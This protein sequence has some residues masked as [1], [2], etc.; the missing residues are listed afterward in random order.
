M[1]PVPR[2]TAPPKQLQR[3]YGLPRRMLL[4]RWAESKGDA[5][6]TEALVA[7]T[8]DFWQQYR[9]KRYTYLS[10]AG[11]HRSLDLQDWGLMYKDR[12]GMERNEIELL[13]R[14]MATTDVIPQME[15]LAFQNI[16][17]T[18]PVFRYN[19]ISG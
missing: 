10:E 2:S 14:F 15:Y 7:H 19:R 18:Y 16:L 6:D 1:N 4:H 9:T 17:D 8:I 13:Y 11:S 3:D 12:T 5:F